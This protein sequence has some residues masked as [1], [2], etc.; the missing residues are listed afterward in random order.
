MCK[1]CEG[2][3]KQDEYGFYI[4]QHKGN[5]WLNSIF[6]DIVQESSDINYCPMCG[7]KLKE[8]TNE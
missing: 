2:K 4:E 7:R 5:W 8:E 1:Y 3:E 6:Y